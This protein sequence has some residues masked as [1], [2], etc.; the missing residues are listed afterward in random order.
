MTPRR[1]ALTSDLTGRELLRWY[2]RKDEL[3]SFARRIGVGTGG[4]KQEL[5]ARLAAALDGEPFTEPRT[6][7]RRPS[8]PRLPE[9][10]T[11]DTVLPEGQRCSQQLRAFFQ[12]RIGPAFHFDA[13]MR[14]FVATGAG[15][16]LGEAVTHWHATRDAGRPAIG[17]QFELNRFLREWHAAHPGAGRRAALQAWREHRSLPVDARPGA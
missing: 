6:T 5:T 2:W 11:E 9:P 1:P 10:L 13:A 12:Q 8:A 14:D 16:T 3:V 17:A 15:R 7:A 4:G